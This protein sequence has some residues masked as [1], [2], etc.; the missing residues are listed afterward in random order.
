MNIVISGVFGFIGKY[1]IEYFIEVGYWVVFLGR[2]MFCEG[3]LG[4][5]IQVLLYC[6]VIINLVG[7]FIGKWWILEYKK[8]FYDSW[9]K[10]MY[11]IIWVMDVVKMKLWLM[12]FV[13][14]VGYYLEE[15]IFDEYINIWGS[16]FLVE[17][18]Y[19]WEKEVCCCLLQIRLVIICFGI[20][21]LFDGGVM[22]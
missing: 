11:C 4:Y 10:V 6:D 16:G 12:I 21:L 2:F 9:I 13:F 22:E 20:V 17:F 7:V 18:C 14:V 19:V 5:L 3:I 15:G 1:F 8:E